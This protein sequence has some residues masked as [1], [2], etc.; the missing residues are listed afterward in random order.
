MARYEDFIDAVR[1]RLAETDVEQAREAVARTVA[2]LVL[3][4]PREER[5]AFRDALPAPLRPAD[6]EDAGTAG[7]D[8]STFV[9][10]VAGREGRPPERVRYEVQAV[11]SAFEAMEP[12]A[13][14]RVRRSLPDDFGEL[15][16]A[17]GGGPPPDLAAGDGVPPAEL[18]DEDVRALLRRLPEWTGDRRRLSRPVAPPDYLAEQLFSRI[19]EL[20]R[21]LNR[22]AVVVSE[23]D[24]SYRIDVW[25]HSEGLV[26]DLDAT[27]ATAVED[28]IDDVLVQR[29]PASSPPP[30][31]ERQ[32]TPPRP[33]AEPVP[34]TSH[35][36]SRT[37]HRDD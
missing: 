31:P 2:G 29:R 23:P 13:A 22:R 32:V 1:E 20:E 27:F 17:P 16:T 5:P 11:L 19:R 7:G 35:R 3:W 34:G 8:P 15:F 14:R 4:L 25:T 6:I 9:T 10:F 37:R 30:P 26:T 12:E 33:P 28:V 21:T 36:R 24:G 18:T